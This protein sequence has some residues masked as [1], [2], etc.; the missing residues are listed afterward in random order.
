MTLGKSLEQ[1]K[2][3]TKLDEPFISFIHMCLCFNH[4]RI[5]LPCLE[6]SLEST[7]NSSQVL[8]SLQPF[9]ISNYSS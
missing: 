3:P 6:Y 1:M 2:I 9:I 5:K 4:Q 8:A 7:D